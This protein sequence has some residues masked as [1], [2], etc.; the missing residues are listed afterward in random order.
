MRRP[1]LP[2]A[3]TDLSLPTLGRNS[4]RRSRVRKPLIIAVVLTGGSLL[5]GAGKKL[6]DNR[7][8]TGESQVRQTFSLDDGRVV[9]V[10][11]DVTFVVAA[12]DSTIV[13]EV[14]KPGKHVAYEVTR[15]SPTG[16]PTG[17]L[18]GLD[19]ES[20]TDVDDADKD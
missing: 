4:N 18:H 7:F 1:Q 11:R 6:F 10:L 17:R 5:V 9:V 15:W 14:A 3:L 2:A 19:D 8:K 12:E 16:I 20:P 13:T